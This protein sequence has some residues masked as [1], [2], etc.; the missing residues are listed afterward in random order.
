[1]DKYPFV[2]TVYR[3]PGSKSPTMQQHHFEDLVQATKKLQDVGRDR[4]VMKATLSVILMVQTHN[5][6]RR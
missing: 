6:D 5:S 4:F 2:V 3:H 1:M